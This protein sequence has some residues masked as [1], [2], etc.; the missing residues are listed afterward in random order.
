M[1]DTLEVLSRMSKNG[2]KALKLSPLSNIK[3]ARS[4]KEG[5]GE[6][7]IALPN[8]LI[9]KLTIKPDYYIGGLILCE[10]S[11]FKKEKELM[12]SEDK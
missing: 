10:R 5:W 9:S 4:G 12:E 1:P 11:E 2:N 8:E 7:T 3:S 6:V